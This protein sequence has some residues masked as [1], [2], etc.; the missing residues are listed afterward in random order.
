PRSVAVSAPPAGP[1]KKS[2]SWS[3]HWL[4]RG[5]SAAWSSARRRKR[6]AES[7]APIAELVV[8]RRAIVTLSFCMPM[9]I[10]WLVRGRAQLAPALV[11]VALAASRAIAQEPARPFGT[12]RE[13][14]TLQQHWLQERLDSVLPGLMRKYDIDMWVVPMREYNED[15]VFSALVSPTTFS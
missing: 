9:T 14:A 10:R 13:Q 11:V 6:S 8:G 3:K 4:P 5:A 15:P 1:M 12:L 2:A 7:A